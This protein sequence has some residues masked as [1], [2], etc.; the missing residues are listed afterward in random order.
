[1]PLL[2]LFFTSSSNLEKIKITTGD[3]WENVWYDSMQSQ[4][5]FLKL[6]ICQN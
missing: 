5:Y 1:M 6:M 3:N 4:W 2:L